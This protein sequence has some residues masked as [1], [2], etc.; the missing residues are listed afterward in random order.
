MGLV[1]VNGILN[2]L[3]YSDVFLFFSKNTQI[4]WQIKLCY[5]S[6]IKFIWSW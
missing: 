4:W 2:I 6:L 3:A 5:V 1:T